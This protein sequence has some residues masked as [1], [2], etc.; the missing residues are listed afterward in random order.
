MNSDRSEEVKLRLY[1]AWGLLTQSEMCQADGQS[2]V[3]MEYLARRFWEPIYVAIRQ[4]RRKAANVTDLTQDFFV[5]VLEKGILDRFE[6]KRGKLRS[7]LMGVLKNFLTDEY[8][9]KGAAKRGGN[10]R[11]LSLEGM[12]SLPPSASLEGMEPHHIFEQEW[13]RV[14]IQ[15]AW[16]RMETEGSTALLRAY[17]ADPGK[18]GSPAYE[19]LAERFGKTYQGIANELHRARRM[20]KQFIMEEIQDYCTGELEVREELQDFCAAFQKS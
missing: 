8:R 6:R 11:L 15:R 17:L 16:A 19:K 14:V 7:F 13:A 2:R 9:R 3:A 1:R 18:K 12:V 5:Y 10:Q 20:L 4:R